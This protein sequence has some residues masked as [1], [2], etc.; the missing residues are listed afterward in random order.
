MSGVC[1]PAPS[2]KPA[3]EP[4]PQ[5]LTPPVPDEDT[6]LKERLGRL[7]ALFAFV[8]YQMTQ[9]AELAAAT[10]RLSPPP[11]RAPSCEPTVMDLA[12]IVEE[13]ETDLDSDSDGPSDDVD[14]V[15]DAF[16]RAL[17]SLSSG[18]AVQHRPARGQ[19]VIK[20]RPSQAKGINVLLTVAG[21]YLKLVGGAE[22][23]QEML[24]MPFHHVLIRMVPGHDNMFHILV[25][26]KGNTSQGILIS[27]GDRSTRDK[28][29]ATLSSMSINIQD[30]RPSPTM[31][32]D[33][34][35]ERTLANN[36]A[37]P[38]VRWIS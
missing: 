24:S 5:P 33:W 31:A 35:V 36:G 19:V 14:A 23:D 9:S 15:V 22:L 1:A 29:L 38:L 12:P 18:P 2:A 10:K 7:D 11:S 30:W 25:D 13:D 26:K 21:G 8:E 32:R 28:W 34:K 4:Q 20:A 16:M 17:S 6:L 37:L 27:L 3:P